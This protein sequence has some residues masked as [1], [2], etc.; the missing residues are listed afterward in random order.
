MRHIMKAISVATVAAGAVALVQGT[1]QA[2]EIYEEN[3]GVA[4][5]SPP[6]STCSSVYAGRDL[7]GQACFT[8]NG[9]KFWIRDRRADGLHIEARGQANLTGDGF[10]CYSNTNGA[11]P[12]RVCDSFAAKIPEG[13]TIAFTPSAW[14]GNTQ[15]HVGELRLVRAG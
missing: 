12:W 7:A 9:D 13:A 1:A 14:K 10:R 5:D 6:S 3:A 11:G 2:R 4:N 8:P 15:K